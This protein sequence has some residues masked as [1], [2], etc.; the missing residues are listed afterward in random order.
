MIYKIHARDILGQ[1]VFHEV[2]IGDRKIE[3]HAPDLRGVSL[4]NAWLNGADLRCANLVGACLRG[5]R[6]READLSHADLSGADLSY[7]DLRGAHFENA[8][9]V[10]TILYPAETI[11]AKF[12]GAKFTSDSD[13]ADYVRIGR[14]EMIK[15][16]RIHPNSVAYRKLQRINGWTCPAPSPDIPPVR[17]GWT[18]CFVESI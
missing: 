2:E 7:C 16:M 4:E 8:N 14:E 9:L 18:R 5:A 13:A 1:P 17:R 6:L 15:K 12:Y 10:G 3:V 11:G